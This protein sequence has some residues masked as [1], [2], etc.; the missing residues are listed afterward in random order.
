M[1]EANEAASRIADWPGLPW[2]ALA[3]GALLYAVVRW[4]LRRAPESVPAAL[5]GSPVRALVFWAPV[6]LGLR[7]SV[8]RHLS[9][10]W[11]AWA[12]RA[13]VL[14]FVAAMTLAAVRGVHRGYQVAKKGFPDMDPAERNRAL[15]LRKLG[16]AGVILVGSL[17]AL[18][19]LGVDPA[20]LLAGGA[21]GGIV[22]G[23]ALQESL[24]SVF[25]GLFLTWD[26]SVRIGDVVRLP[27]GQ[28]GTVENVGWR[29]TQV[30]L[31]DQTLLIVPNGVF[32]SSV[33]TNLSR[34]SPETSVVLD[35]AVAYGTD[36]AAAEQLVLAE[37]RTV[38]QKYGP[39][40]AGAPPVL[41]WRELGENGVA[42]RVFVPIERN[43][44][45][46]PARSDLV[47]ALHDAFQSA[48]VRI[49]APQR[50]L[51]VLPKRAQ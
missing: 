47:K 18:G 48:K 12:D 38:Q 11:P 43:A 42:F 30:R 45:V 33:M 6:L 25:A 7:L 16:V 9:G 28:E 21:V 17:A 49:P 37:A 51:T 39:G 15:V 31:P 4:A 29:N 20:P 34:P 23:L 46:Y 19:A 8:E 40:K 10:G 3:L 2:A 13:A 50:E 44:D 41:R 5:L 22:L 1:P 14:A 35:A 26:G 32:A 36:L 24:S 27:A